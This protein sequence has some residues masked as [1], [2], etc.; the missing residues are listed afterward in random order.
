MIAIIDYRAGNATSV[1]RALRYLRQ[2][3]RITDDPAVV[4]A[5]DRVIF[6]GVGAAGAAMDSLRQL[7]LDTLLP[8]LIARGTP[9]LGICLG[10]QLLFECS[11]EDHAQCLGVLPGK[12]VRFADDMVDRSTEMPLKIPHIGWNQ[13]LFP[14]P[15]PLWR[16]L[17]APGDFYFVHSYY[18]IPRPDPALCCLQARYGEK[19]AAGVVRNNLAAFQF[20]PEKSGEVGLRLLDNFCQW[21]PA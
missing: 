11:Q 5:A 17:S 6:P 18:P 14:G 21:Q 20:H 16:G 13:V 19:F 3:A 15:H 9:F 1:L 12:V 2:D 10:Y 7:G 8:R 4:A